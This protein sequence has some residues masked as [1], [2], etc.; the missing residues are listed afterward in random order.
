MYKDYEYEDYDEEELDEVSKAYISGM[1]DA[2]KGMQKVHESSPKD[3]TAAS[4]Y[5]RIEHYLTDEVNEYI[6]RTLDA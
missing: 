3:E 6:M 1:R 4:L 5:E 2:L